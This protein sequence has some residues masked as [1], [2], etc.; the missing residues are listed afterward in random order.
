MPH[1]LDLTTPEQLQTIE[2]AQRLIHLAAALIPETTIYNPTKQNK[3]EYAKLH[4]ESPIQL[5]HTPDCRQ[6][7]KDIMPSYRDRYMP[8]FYIPGQ[9]IEV[10][11]HREAVDITLV[12][13]WL[14]AKINN[15][16]L[17]ILRVKPE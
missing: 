5:R 15:L 13:F 8:A 1:L 9:F 10:F 17:T 2:T 7:M 4:L 6:K 11:D 16:A 14:K 3:I 12:A